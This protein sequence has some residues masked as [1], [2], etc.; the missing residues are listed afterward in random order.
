M[1]M[2]KAAPFRR[3]RTHPKQVAGTTLPWEIV[4]TGVLGEPDLIFLTE[5][6]KK[7]RERETLKQHLLIF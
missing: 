2:R 5:A 7:K 6:G 1:S 3:Q 4:A